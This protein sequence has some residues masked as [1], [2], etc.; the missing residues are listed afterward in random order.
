MITIHDRYNFGSIKD[1]FFALFL[2][3]EQ[4]PLVLERVDLNTKRRYLPNA[5]ALSM[6]LQLSPAD[7][8]YNPETTAKS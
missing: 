7:R 2:S 6:F 1:S 8:T 4:D 3:L 5:I